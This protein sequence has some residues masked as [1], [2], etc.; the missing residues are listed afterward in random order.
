MPQDK[1]KTIAK[2]L[3]G[4]YISSARGTRDRKQDPMRFLLKNIENKLNTISDETDERKKMDNIYQ[5]IQQIQ[6]INIKVKPASS[7][8]ISSFFSI[9]KKKPALPTKRLADLLAENHKVLL[10]DQPSTS[11]LTQEAIPENSAGA[12]VYLQGQLFNYLHEKKDREFAYYLYKKSDKANAITSY[13]FPKNEEDE[14]VTPGIRNWQEDLS[15]TATRD[16]GFIDFNRGYHLPG[17]KGGETN[18][19]FANLIDEMV[20]KAVQYT[21]DE[22]K[23]LSTFLRDHGG[24]HMNQFIVLSFGDGTFFSTPYSVSTPSNFNNTAWYI[25]DTGKIGLHQEVEIKTLRET[26]DT[27]KTTTTYIDPALFAYGQQDSGKKE[28]HEEAEAYL[29]SIKHTMEQNYKPVG[30]VIQKSNIDAP[31]PGRDLLPP[32]CTVKTDIELKI[33]TNAEGQKKVLPVV[34]DWTVD[35]YTHLLPLKT[36][37]LTIT[38]EPKPEKSKSDSSNALGQTTETSESDADAGAGLE[39]NTPY[40][41]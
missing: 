13:V 33:V 16:A 7:F 11:T 15:K 9:G 23:L 26:D 29:N 22:K 31:L 14:I 38:P 20:E 6:N 34:K 37:T 25:T 2:N 3:Q 5:L 32:V 4:I 1:L 21:K 35:S 19:E 28:S 39:K 27:G 30:T 18:D 41:K 12:L 40:K 36:P 8:S 10:R 24:Q 17:F